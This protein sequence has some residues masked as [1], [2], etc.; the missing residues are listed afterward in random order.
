MST[1]ANTGP[2]ISP[3]G[4]PMINAYRIVL[5]ASA[6]KV[7]TANVGAGCGGVIPCAME[8][9]AS[10]GKPR[11]RIGT[12]IFFAITNANGTRRRKPTSK[13]NGKPIRK[14]AKKSVQGTYFRPPIE[15]MALANASAPPEETNNPPIIV[16]RPITMPTKLSMSES[17]GKCRNRFNRIDPTD[18]TQSPRDEHESEKRMPFEPRYEQDQQNDAN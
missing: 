12:S 10:I 11:L 6:W 14:A 16:P 7:A 4:N 17:L 8:R 15:I 5:P 13:N 3:T 18:Y 9:P 2:E 1:E